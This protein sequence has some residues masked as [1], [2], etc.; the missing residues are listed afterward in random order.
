[1]SEAWPP[2]SW[3][4][5]TVLAA[6][7]GGADSV[8]LLR[9]LR[10]LKKEGDGGLLAAHFNHRLRGGESDAD[11]A[12][13]ANLCRKTDVKCEVGRARGDHFAAASDGVEAAARVARYDFL[14]ETAARVGARYVVTGHTADDQ[15]ETILHRILRGTGIAGLGGMARARPLGPAAT[16]I[17]PLLGFRRNE[18]VAYLAEL[19]QPFRSDSSNADRAFTRNRIRCQLLPELAEQYNPEV[20]A[21]LLRLGRLAGEVQ[22]VVDDLVADLQA[23]AV[24][25]PS[26][27]VARISLTALAGQPPYI[28]RELFMA[29][30]RHSDWPLQSMGFREWDL[31][32]RMALPC[33]ALP[34]PTKQMLPG[35]I[36]A[37]TRSDG[38]RLNRVFPR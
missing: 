25:Y 12:F 23:R 5:V 2:A 21:A 28:V 32:A 33:P 24:A 26:P 22:T 18:L 19:G 37:E 8:A 7:S 11:E 16:L 3:H 34:A 13:V 36:L 30:W 10:S 38:L 6:V 20:V 35:G 4:D 29:V 15:A 27:G 9:I 14:R 17:R 31:L 1:M